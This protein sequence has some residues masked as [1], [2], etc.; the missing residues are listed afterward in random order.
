MQAVCDHNRGIFDLFI[1]NPGSVHDSRVFRNSPLFHSCAK[2][3]RYFL[4]ADSGYPL[5]PNFL[6]AYKD[7]G[8]LTRR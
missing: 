7:W 5:D 8:N 3:E 4:L 6:M 2:C 1:G